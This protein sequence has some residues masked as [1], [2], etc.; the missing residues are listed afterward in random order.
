MRFG[1]STMSLWPRSMFNFTATAKWLAD[2]GYDC[3]QVVCQRGIYGMEK[4]AIP[5]EYIEKAWNP[6]WSPIQGLPILK[7]ILA[8]YGDE[9]L[10]ASIVDWLA[11]PTPPSCYQTWC[12]LQMRTPRPQAISHNF[13]DAVKSGGRL[14]EVHPEL[15]LTVTEIMGMCQRQGCGLVIDTAHQYRDWRDMKKD[16]QKPHPLGATVEE[17]VAAVALLAPY[18]QLLHIKSVTNE[19]DRQVVGTLMNARPTNLQAVI[20]EYKPCTDSLLHPQDFAH[21]FLND[22]RELVGG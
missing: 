3:L 11:F 5:V 6:V 19:L 9:K 12:R 13:F 4:T 10:P 16:G 15:G 1:I 8:L 21:D 20:A 22:M 17:R 2:L 14:V 7:N 18:V